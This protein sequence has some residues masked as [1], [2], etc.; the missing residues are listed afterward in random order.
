MRIVNT[1][2]VKSNGTDILYSGIILDARSKEKAIEICNDYINSL[3]MWKNM[4]DVQAYELMH[5]TTQFI[6]CD[7]AKLKDAHIGTMHSDATC[8]V[9]KV[10][11]YYSRENGNLIPQ[12]IGLRVDIFGSN[13]PFKYFTKGLHSHITVALCNSNASA[14]NTDKCFQ[15]IDSEIEFSTNINIDPVLMSGKFEFVNTKHVV[16]D[17]LPDYPTLY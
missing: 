7:I 13:L 8:Y 14:K 12:N 17:E 1:P 4:P 6:G 11:I 10:G 3:P 5:C 2:L 9:N 16:I 15:N